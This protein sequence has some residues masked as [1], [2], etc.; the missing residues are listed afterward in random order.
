MLALYHLS[1]TYLPESQFMTLTAF[2][3][4]WLISF[5]LLSI[6]TISQC[7]PALQSATAAA[8]AKLRLPCWLTLDYSG[9]EQLQC[10]TMPNT[11]E[12]MQL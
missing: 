7:Q 8:A 4:K 3:H 12:L 6:A 5:S 11:E 1:F 9:W 2:S 10:N